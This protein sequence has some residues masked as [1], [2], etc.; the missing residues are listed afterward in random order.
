MKT[1][2][3]IRIKKHSRINPKSS[4]GLGKKAQ[5]TNEH[6]DDDKNN[7]ATFLPIDKHVCAPSFLLQT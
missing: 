3:L 1:Y 4:L 6:Q 5:W 7:M 2:R